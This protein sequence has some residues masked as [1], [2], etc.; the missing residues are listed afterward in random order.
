MFWGDRHGRL[1]DPCGN[2]WSIAARIEDVS[3]EE[4]AARIRKLGSG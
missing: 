3:P 1:V 2:Q 4:M